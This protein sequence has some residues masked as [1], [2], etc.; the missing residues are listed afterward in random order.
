MK[1][2]VLTF[3]DQN[4]L[5]ELAKKLVSFPS[6]PP[7]ETPAAEFLAKY[8]QDAGIETEM[9]EVEPGRMQ[10]LGRLRG[11]EGGPSMMFNGHLDIDPM[12]LELEETWRKSRRDPFNAVVE[13]GRFYGQGIGNMKGGVAAMIIAAIA[14]KRAKIPLK[15]DLLVASVVG[16]LQ[17]G[18][19]T[20]Y[21]VQKKILT[22]YALVPEPS[23]LTIRLFTAGVIRLLINTIGKSVH[24]GSTHVRKPVH[25][26]EKMC[27]VVNALKDTKFTYRPKPE[28]PHLPRMVV[29]SI[30]GG[31]TR[32]YLLWRAAYTPDFCTIACDIRTVPGMTA[33][34]VVADIRKVLE[35]I[36]EEDPEFQYE[37][38]LPPATYRAPWKTTKLVR[39]PYDMPRDDPI[40]EI[41]RMNHRHVRGS[42]PDIGAGYELG[43]HAGNDAGWLYDAGAKAITYGPRNKS[44]TM[45]DGTK[46][47][48]MAVDDMLTVARVYALSAVDVC[49][50]EK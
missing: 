3:I 10:P 23:G 12:T 49:T 36:K 22:D 30:I 8:M 40:V 43:S 32:D 28:V 7:D 11:S 6:Y 18:V 42:D 47:E 50:K 16:E 46:E 9:M 48:Y 33:D 31:V 35:P 29:G 13:D 20:H 5:I 17:G 39:P 41:V 2:K 1:D 4:E 38:E 44:R 15:G 19:G 26:L 25:A 24:V 45:P 34:S 21:L 37:I 27:K 14:V